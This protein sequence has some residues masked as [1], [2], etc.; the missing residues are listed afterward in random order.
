MAIFPQAVPQPQ[1]CGSISA[2]GSLLLVGNLLN[3]ADEPDLLTI[4]NTAA[5]AVAAT[6]L[7]LSSS[8]V[9]AQGATVLRKGG[10]LYFGVNK[11]IVTADTTI[12]IGTPTAVPV[13]PLV[14]AIAANATAQTWALQRV[15]APQ[16]IPVNEESSTTDITDLTYGLQGSETVTKLMLNPS[17]SVINR[18]DDRA[19]NDIIHG[20]AQIGGTIYAVIAGSDTTHVFGK[21]VVSGFNKE[22]AQ[23]DVTKP[24]FTL[25][26]QA[27]YQSKKMFRYLTTA[28]QL[29]VNQ[30]RRAAGLTELV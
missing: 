5:A 7:T 18:F 12:A 13:E 25:L 6:S 23:S 3:C 4:T 19:I 26:Y 11:A 29:L 1:N 21:A 10:I 30:A 9:L 15:L 28:E 14:A 20:A 27:G 17:I 2:Q 16:T 22:F 24:S 8:A